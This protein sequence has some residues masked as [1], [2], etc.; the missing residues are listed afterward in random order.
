MEAYS[1]WGMGRE[2]QPGQLVMFEDR[3]YRCIA[4]ARA[5]QSPANAPELWQG[6]DSR[7]F[8]VPSEA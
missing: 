5:G 4:V 1:Q 7:R 3:L 2:Y 8:S 6:E